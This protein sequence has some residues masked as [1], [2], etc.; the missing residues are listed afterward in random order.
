MYPSRTREALPVRTTENSEHG[1]STL[2]RR[3]VDQESLCGVIGFEIPLACSTG[4]VVDVGGAEMRQ[5]PET[6]PD[7]TPTHSQLANSAVH[8]AVDVNVLHGV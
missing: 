7:G 2:R 8:D 6:A 5:D 3:R 4:D 1:S